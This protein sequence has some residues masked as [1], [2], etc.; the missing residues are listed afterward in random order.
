V[1]EPRTTPPGS[2]RAALPPP[3]VVTTTYSLWFKP[4]EKPWRPWSDEYV[5]QHMA[6]ATGEACRKTFPEAKIKVLRTVTTRE[7]VDV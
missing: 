7:W 5:E 2:L 4:P 1:S 3:F 6:E